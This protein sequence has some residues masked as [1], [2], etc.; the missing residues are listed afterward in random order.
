MRFR[1]FIRRDHDFTGLFV[2]FRLVQVNC[3]SHQSAI[4]QASGIDVNMLPGFWLTLIFGIGVYDNFQIIYFSIIPLH[5]LDRPVQLDH[6]QVD[7]LD[8]ENTLWASLACYN[9]VRTG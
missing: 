5:A 9:Y 1:S 8:G 3:N 4:W 2:C 6:V 7:F